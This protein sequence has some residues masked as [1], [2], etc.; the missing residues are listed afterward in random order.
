MNIHRN[1][2]ANALAQGATNG[3]RSSRVGL[4]VLLWA[5]GCNSKY[6]RHLLGNW[7]A[8]KALLTY[9]HATGRFKDTY[10]GLPMRLT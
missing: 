6:M 3:N 9:I 7:C 5:M 2:L 8:Y 10:G 4:P 1:E